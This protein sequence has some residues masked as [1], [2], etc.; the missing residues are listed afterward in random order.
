MR[1]RVYWRDEV[2]G[3]EEL[4][5]E[6]AVLPETCRQEAEVRRWDMEGEGG[7]GAHILGF[8]WIIKQ[9]QSGVGNH[10]WVQWLCKEMEKAELQD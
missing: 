9:K 1:C 10:W 8:A 5:R 4:A 3:V 7:G 6:P 2:D